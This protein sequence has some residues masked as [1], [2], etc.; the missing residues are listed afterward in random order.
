MPNQKLP[1]VKQMADARGFTLPELLIAMAIFMIVGAA[2]FSL[3]AQN[4]PIFNQ[5]QNLAEVNISLRNAIA[6]MQID[7]ASA[8][9]NY[10]TA[11]ASAGAAPPANP[12]GITITNS[13]VASNADCR[14]GTPPAYTA[15]CFDQMS[16]IS[17]DNG[18]PVTNPVSGAGYTGAGA[19]CIDTTTGVAYL[20]PN[21]STNGYGSGAGGLLAAT[22]AAGKYQYSAAGYKD[23]VLFVSNDGAKYS[24]AKLSAAPT[25]QSIGGNYYVKLSYGATNAGGLNTAGATGNDPYNLTT[26]TPTQAILTNNF[27]AGGVG[28]PDYLLRI[29]PITYKVDITTDATN[30]SLLRQVAGLAQTTAQQTLATQ[31]IGFKIGASL[32]DNATST[33]TPTYCFDSS[34]YDPTCRNPTFNPPAYAYNYM[35]VRSIMVSL[36]GRTNPNPGPQYVFRNTF[37]G[38]PYEIQGVSAV[39]NPRNMSMND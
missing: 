13:V 39:M 11:L 34:Q 16:I 18:T 32:F 38:G 33:D 26:N 17:V 24:T 2:G 27:C 19:S 4:Q 37:D 25:T 14:N 3:L 9:Q 10:L 20:T 36:I 7:M 29:V 8:G 15:A 21:G 35:V 1:P 22:A 6:Q 12:I 28:S 31:I 5:Q 30:P 23:Q